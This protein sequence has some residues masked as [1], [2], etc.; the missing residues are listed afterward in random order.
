MV[1]LTLSRIVSS[2][3][4]CC[5]QDH[6]EETRGSRRLDPAVSWVTT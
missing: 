4:A 5:R 1:S 3:W 6:D 2:W